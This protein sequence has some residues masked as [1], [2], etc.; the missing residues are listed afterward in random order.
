MRCSRLLGRAFVKFYSLFGVKFEN[1][2][3][4]TLDFSSRA[5]GVEHGEIERSELRG[6]GGLPP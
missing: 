6:F 4:D 1:Y 3:G 5:L 2:L